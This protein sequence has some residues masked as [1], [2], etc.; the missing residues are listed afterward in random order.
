MSNN[1]S[2]VIS[3]PCLPKG[4]NDTLSYSDIFEVPCTIGL[5]PNG[6]KSKVSSCFRHQHEHTLSSSIT[7]QQLTECTTPHRVYNPTQSVQPHTECTTPHKVYNPTQSV[8]PHTH[9]TTPHT[10]YNPTH[11][12]QPHTHCTTPHTV[13]NPT[14]SVQ[15][16]TQCTTPHRVNVQLVLC[17]CQGK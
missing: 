2:S 6:T 15:P 9:C 4:D 14:Y 13:Y 7:A 17:W 12:V 3:D 1:S 10:V 11:S 5:A 16:H 8:Q